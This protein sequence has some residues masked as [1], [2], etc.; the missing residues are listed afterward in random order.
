MN[1]TRIPLTLLLCVLSGCLFDKESTKPEASGPAGPFA[2]LFDI[3]GDIPPFSSPAMR[4]VAACFSSVGPISPIL[5]PR[6]GGVAVSVD[7]LDG[8][9]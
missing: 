4:R 3:D 1:A 7:S 9:A 6:G 8:G 5:A 2:V